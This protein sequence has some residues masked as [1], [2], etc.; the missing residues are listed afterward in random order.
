[1]REHLKLYQ[2]EIISKVKLS[3][4][5][6]IIDIGSNDS[7]ML[8]YYDKK[9]KRIGVDPTGNQFK[10]FYGDVELIPTYFTYNNFRNIYKDLKPKI[11]SSI[12]MFYDLPDP[13]QFAKDIYNI[14]DDDG[15]WTCE[16]SYIITMLRRNSIDT[17]CHEHLEYYS[18][19]AI[20]YIADL[21]NFKIFDIKFN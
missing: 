15:I 11:I 13:V 18:L 20:K 5:D 8:Q 21:A 4:C 6:V 3:D 9:Y 10:D 12:S 7:T 2:E 1:M 17:I 14:L 19:T 16:Q